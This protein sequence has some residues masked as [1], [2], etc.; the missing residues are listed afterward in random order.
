MHKY[1]SPN[2]T[3][4]H[5]E[6]SFIQKLLHVYLQKLVVGLSLELRKLEKDI[7][8]LVYGFCCILY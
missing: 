3:S 1:F 7:D 4:K 5:I 6:Y 2:Y 8:P